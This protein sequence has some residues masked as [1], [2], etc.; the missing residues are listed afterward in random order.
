MWTRSRFGRLALAALAAPL[1]VV[2]ATI[3][4]TSGAFCAPLGGDS[5]I[6]A[7][8]DVRSLL[9]GSE[10]VNVSVC[11]EV[12]TS[13]KRAVNSV[14]TIL[15]CLSV[16]T[17]SSKLQLSCG[18]DRSLNKMSTLTANSVATLHIALNQAKP[19]D[20]ILLAP[21]TYTGFVL[22]GLQIPGN[23]TISSLDPSN[24]AVIKDFTLSGVQGLTFK[25]LEFDN[26]GSTK[27]VGSF[28]VFDSK[29]IH[30]V[31]SSFHGSLDGDPT[32][33]AD[34]LRI[35]GGS[36]ISITS[37]EFQQFRNALGHRDVDG[38]RISENY[39][40]DI[41][42]DGV[43]GSGSHNIEITGNYFTNF[44]SVEGDHADA[45]QFF[46]GNTTRSAE[47]ITISGNL[48]V[49]GNGS[50]I[51]GIFLRDEKGNLPYLNL[52]IF[53][54]TVVGG[55]Y[56]A[57]NVTGAQKVEISSNTIIGAADRVTRINVNETIGAVVRDNVAPHYIFKTITG[58]T[59]SNNLFNE[60]YVT[61]WQAALKNWAT[62]NLTLAAT[63]PELMSSLGLTA[64]IVSQPAPAPEPTP[65][66]PPEPPPAPAPVASTIY[67]GASYTLATNEAN[68]ELTGNKGISGVG[69]DLGN[70]ITGNSGHNQLSGLDG[71]DTISGGDG[72]DFVRGDAGDDL[73]QGN[74]G[75]DVI[76]GG[77]GNDTAL[78][79]KGHDSIYGE[80][81]NDLLYG[82]D[83]DDRIA[84]NMGNDTI[85]GG[86]GKDVL[87]GGQGDDVIYGGDGSDYLSGDMGNDV[88]W[89]GAGADTFNM[90]QG[91]GVNRVMDF[92]QKEGDKVLLT[93]AKSY[94]VS[95]VGSD[96][97]VNLGGGDQM[98]LVGVDMS[99]LKSG[100]IMAG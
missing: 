62:T 51:Q 78:G 22:K 67:S 93:G 18:A 56:N 32:N 6:V 44:R 46:T 29:N 52:K 21:G 61:D 71:N 94:T 91:F 90:Q 92:S 14:D 95:Q 31:K 39:F 5:G 86:A 41:R 30:F 59:E 45:I 81:G 27:Q 80:D 47:N 48:I 73:L 79:G 76:Y 69:N 12:T 16:G 75:N 97:V 88:L 28:E 83:G 8:A 87:M 35:V 68:L 42:T 57:I 74:A 77:T 66:P 3:G 72:N 1:V 26:T 2:A 49:Q 36:N 64:P 98:I 20:T 10:T 53:E 96:T 37:S 60:R 7:S 85:Y 99:A 9:S 17:G 11:E 58:L 63:H 19:G 65:V 38:L 4:F 25:G 34:G 43:R 33:D 24:V 84:G 70:V 50:H 40:H 54:N 23:V 82:D 89:G 100:W 13:L 55:N 15:A